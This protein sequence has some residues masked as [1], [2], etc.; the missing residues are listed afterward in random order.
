ML[1]VSEETNGT[2]LHRASQFFSHPD[3]NSITS[4]NDIGLIQSATTFSEKVG[5]VC[6]PFNR[7]ALPAVGETLTAMGWDRTSLPTSEV[8][9][10]VIL[11]V[12]SINRCVAAYNNTESSGKQVCTF[13]PGEVTCQM[14]TGGPLIVIDSKTARVFQAG[15]V[16][17]D[18]H[19]G[20][21]EL[22]VSTKIASYLD[23]IKETTKE[24]FCIK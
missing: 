12:V 3:Y 20:G 4:W 14:D 9:L 19:C 10:K 21:D 2:R 8:L 16:P 7:P 23:W 22:A 15:I 5:P 24:K 17:L 6:L 1:C 13:A 11:P 18:G